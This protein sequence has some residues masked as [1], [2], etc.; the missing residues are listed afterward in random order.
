LPEWRPGTIVTIYIGYGLAGV[1]EGRAAAPAADIKIT[2]ATGWWCASATRHLLPL[3]VRRAVRVGVS[4]RLT[5]PPGIVPIGATRRQ[6][7]KARVRRGS[8]RQL[9]GE[10]SIGIH[11]PVPAFAYTVYGCNNSEVRAVVSGVGTSFGT[12]TVVR[13]YYPEWLTV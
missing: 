3:T 13:R 2:P 5:S 9:R 12:R 7:R 11:T 6:V 8:Q 1:V 4:D 10:R